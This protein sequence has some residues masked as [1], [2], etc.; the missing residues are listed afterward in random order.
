MGNK[1]WGHQV[2]LSGMARPDQAKGAEQNSNVGPGNWGTKGQVGGVPADTR[3]ASHL[4]GGKAKRNAERE[5]GLGQVFSLA[6]RKW[7]CFGGGGE[8]GEGELG[9][10]GM[11]GTRRSSWR[12]SVLTIPDTQN[13]LVGHYPG[14]KNSY[15]AWIWNREDEPPRVNGRRKIW[16]SQRKK[17]TLVTET[18][19][20]HKWGGGGVAKGGNGLQK[21]DT[22]QPP[23]GGAPQRK[24]ETGVGKEI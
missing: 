13:E 11:N 16:S 8:R 17:T 1:K 2:D 9:Q 7:D 21:T 20:R 3:P 4:K 19:V 5:L 24:N 18:H 6:Q 14:G 22:E 15:N 10:N 23:I 12:H